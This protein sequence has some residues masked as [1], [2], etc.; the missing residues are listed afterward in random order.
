MG[1]ERGVWKPVWKS[2]REESGHESGHIHFMRT[3]LSPLRIL[4]L[5]FFFTPDDAAAEAGT[6]K[7]VVASGDCTVQ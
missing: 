5:F 3:P 6:P 1:G 2:A 4:F 7:F